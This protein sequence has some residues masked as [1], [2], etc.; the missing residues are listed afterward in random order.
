MQTSEVSGLNFV[1]CTNDG[2][3]LSMPLSA[4]VYGGGAIVVEQGKLTLNGKKFHNNKA[5]V[6]AVGGSTK[7]GGG[8]VLVGPAAT[9]DLELGFDRKTGDPDMGGNTSNL[10]LKNDAPY[11]GAIANYGTLNVRGGKFDTNTAMQGP[12]G[13]GLGGAIYS[14]GPIHTLASPETTKFF[15]NKAFLQGGAVYIESPQAASGEPTVTVACDFDQFDFRDN[16]STASGGAVQLH[17]AELTVTNSKFL[18]NSSVQGGAISMIA[19]LQ[20]VVAQIPGAPGGGGTTQAS[21]VTATEVDF[22]G[23]LAAVNPNTNSPNAVF[24]GADC[25][26]VTSKCHFKNNNGV[27]VNRVVLIPPAGATGWYDDPLAGNQSDGVP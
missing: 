6:F 3:T 8:A 19:G 27:N 14:R 13:T 7:P 1:N 2:A 20:V 10:F 11:G 18:R 16:E 25:L 26:F 9:L 24:V 23:N 21:K 12:G 5:P 4:A 22:D 15:D 17:G